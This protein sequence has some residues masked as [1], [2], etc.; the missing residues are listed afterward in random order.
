MP[1]HSMAE[2]TAIMPSPVPLLGKNIITMKVS[3][4]APL[5]STHIIFLLLENALVVVLSLMESP[6]G[7]S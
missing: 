7:V 5:S 2:Y 4:M 3:A 1:H 6:H